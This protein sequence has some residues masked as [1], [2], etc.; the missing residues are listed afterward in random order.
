MPG[1]FL[2]DDRVARALSLTAPGAQPVPSLPLSNLLDPQPRHRTR[3][4]GSSA[5]VLVD[6]GAE[7]AIEAVALLSTSLRAGDT[8]RWRLGAL[9]GLVEATPV[10]DLRLT[11]ARHADLSRRLGLQPGHV[12]LAFRR[13]R[14]A[15]RGRGRCR[16]LRP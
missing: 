8:V 16:A 10:F 11:V 14:H 12:R 13:H 5:A 4:L 2:W 1:A 7:T 6:F 9:E 15:G 3:W